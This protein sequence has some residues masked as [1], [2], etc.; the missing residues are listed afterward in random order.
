MRGAYQ[1]LLTL[2]V[3]QTVGCTQSHDT[4]F[5]A[6][7][8]NET[9]EVSSKPP[10][11]PNTN[12]GSSTATG[13][14]PT[15][16]PA[17]P[18]SPFA[19]A[20]R[21]TPTF[22]T[23]RTKTTV[24][25]DQVK[26]EMDLRVPSGA[27]LHRCIYAQF[28]TDR[29]TAVPKVESHYTVGSHHLLAYRSELTAI[30][31]N[32]AGLLDCFASGAAGFERGSYYEAQQPDEHRELPP[33][34]AH[35]F[36]PGEVVVLEAHYIN[37]TDKDV[38]AHVELITH[39][40]NPDDVKQEAGSIFFNNV[41]I[42]VPPHGTSHSEMSCT[43]SQD[44]NLA[45]LWSHM[46]ARGVNFVAETDDDGA[47]DVLGTLY[48]EKDWS[49]PK[50]RVYPSDPPVVLHAGSHIKFGCD[51]KNDSDQTF[52]FGQSAETNEMCILHGMY[53]PRMPRPAEQCMGGVTSRN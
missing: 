33:G 17:T 7:D 39:T 15:S 31:E 13:T 41:N 2:L 53:W 19:G 40:M 3:S 16:M 46:H 35:L 14:S 32:G 36:Q 9:E 45:L 24:S 48:A 42:S 27:E 1:F 44:I 43:L 22:E 25:D 12:G 11:Q 10:E 26:F 8:S 20:A 52:R 18:L 37:S 30:P 5:S 49:E 38:D 34:I 4:P 51:F 47:E 21:G 29:V 28:P 23:D 50:P 6:D